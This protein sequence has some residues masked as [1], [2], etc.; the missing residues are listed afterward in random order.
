MR[1]ARGS[2]ARRRLN[3]ELG[4]FMSPLPSGSPGL[5]VARVSPAH[6]LLA[7]GGE[8][9]ALECFD[10]RRPVAVTRLENATS[11]G[12][13]VTCLRFDGS[14]TTVA[15]GSQAGKVLLYDLRSSRP[16]LVKDHR[17]ST[18]I[19]DVKWHSGPDEKRRII[20]SCAR[21]VKVW[22]AETGT[23]FTS[24]E[25][26]SDVT[27]TCIWPGSG[28]I[29]MA[30]EA[31]RLVPCF[32]PAL[33]PAPRWCAFLENL[34]EEMEEHEQTVLYDD[35]R[36][37]TRADLERLGL[38]S[39]IGTALLR[40]YMHGFFIDNR[41]YGKAAALVTPFDYAK[42][43]AAKA[44]EKL[45]GERGSRIARQRKLPK[46]NAALAA[47]LA[48]TG[49]CDAGD[50]E[51]EEGGA[52]EEG[53]AGA[54]KAPKAASLLTDQRFAAMFS[55]ADFEVDEMDAEYRQL[56]P[57]APRALVREHYEEDEDEVGG[58]AEPRMYVSRGEEAA[59]AFA[60]LKSL[61]GVKAKPMGERRHEKPT[62]GGANERKRGRQEMT[63]ELKGGRTAKGGRGR[64]RDGGGRGRGRGRD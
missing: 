59:A 56:H 4:R 26:E 13:G 46:V 64:G 8:D 57:H 3:L 50:S 55:D 27:D 9:G 34:T 24:V 40:P 21:S 47:R 11:G 23:P 5:N 41:L 18:P 38:G 1:G 43:R 15:L 62:G 42:F 53:Q 28:L 14:G 22:D 45:E 63:F 16:L 12:G 20:S 32:V 35:Y 19:V 33:G 61:A 60:A 48:A 7:A 39:T 37:V 17:Y 30:T 51:G 25:T 31:K 58:G 54:H 6:G 2:R 44:Q 52:E 36:F 49:E 10:V 29:L